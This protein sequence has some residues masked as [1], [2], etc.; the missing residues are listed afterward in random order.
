MLRT[1]RQ[2]KPEQ[3]EDLYNKSLEIELKVYGPDSTQAA[4]SYNNLAGLYRQ[5][6]SVRVALTPCGPLNT[7]AGV[8]SSS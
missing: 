6:V 5:Q 3:A 8:W 4:S 2:G 1:P 7:G